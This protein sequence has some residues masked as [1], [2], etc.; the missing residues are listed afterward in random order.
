MQKFYRLEDVSWAAGGSRQIRL[1]TLPPG[2]RVRNFDLF[3]DLSGTKDAGDVLDGQ[4]FARSVALIKV[5]NFFNIPGYSL[6][7]LNKQIEGRQVQAPTDANGGGAT[8]DMEFHLRLHFRDPRQ[9]ASDDG[10]LPTELLQGQSI[11]ITFASAT[12]WSVGNFTVTAGTVRAHAELVHETNIPQL[13]V[14]GYIDPGSLTIVL[15]PGVYKDIFILDGTGAGT[16]T[17]AEIESVDM[18]VDGDQVWNN[19]LHEQIVGA[20]NHDAVRT[21][22]SELIDNAVERLPL[23]WHDVFGKSNLSKQPAAEKQV[24][25]QLTGTISANNVRVVFWRAVEKDSSMVERMAVV[26]GAPEG[27]TE[28]EPATVSKTVP[29]AL[30]VRKANGMLPRKG[31][32]LE[33]TL[34]GKLRRPAQAMRKR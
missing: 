10:S 33:R 24:K 9:P 15:P 25:I 31:R 23:A 6:W 19:E 29:T 18:D 3:F 22:Q 20:Y 14:V 13:G 11:E 27:A 32:L 26:T 17:R 30:K 2:M 5:G 4:Q 8:F 21:P 1:N 12:V 7:Q 34:P 16:I 28:Y